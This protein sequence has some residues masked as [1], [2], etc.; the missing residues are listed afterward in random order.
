MKNTR[1]GWMLLPGGYDVATLLPP[2]KIRLRSL[3]A[4]SLVNNVGQTGNLNSLS[5]VM[6]AQ[7]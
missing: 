5:L 2:K 1:Y 6:Q 4:S 7:R 3:Q